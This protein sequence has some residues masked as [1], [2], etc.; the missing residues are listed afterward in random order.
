MIHAFQHD[1]EEPFEVLS[2]AARTVLNPMIDILVKFLRQSA[3]PVHKNV[4]NKIS[5]IPKVR[6]GKHVPLA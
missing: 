3:D 6:S 2:M 5:S 1:L 4:N